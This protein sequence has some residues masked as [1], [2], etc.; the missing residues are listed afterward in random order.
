[1]RRVLVTGATG[2]L[3]EHVLAR[4]PPDCE[5]T[6]FV[7]PASDLSRL[8]AGVRTHVGSL[9]RPETLEAALEG[10]DL[11]LNLA[12]LGFGHAPGVV[13]ACRR[14]GVP[15]S[16]FVGSAAVF[17]TLPARSK[18]VRLEAERC[19]QDSGLSCALL[20]PTMI[21]GTPRDRNIWRLI[22]LLRFSPAVP[23]LRGEGLHQP[24]HVEDVADAVWAAAS[25]THAGYRAYNVGGA[26]ALR[27]EEMIGAIAGGLGRRVLLV[28][29]SASAARAG[30]A[31][32]RLLPFL[33][34]ISAEQIERLREDK[35][36][37]NGPARTAFGY[38][39]RDFQTGVAQE[40]RWLETRP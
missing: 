27:L 6:V 36:V 40:L 17:T 23:V 4:R 18:S 21:Y 11:L 14:A 37:D 2:F 20:R 22:R 1:M 8:P 35:S 29:V 16:V 19:L 15:R 7:R 12:S 24:V 5:L 28:P 26:R 13:A 10:Q 39:P 33:P 3:G 25:L 38:A 30:A 34:R 31:V 32:A 9:D